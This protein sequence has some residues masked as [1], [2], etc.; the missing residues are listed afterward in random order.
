MLSARVRAGGL[1]RALIAGEDPATSRQLTARALQLTKPSSRAAIARALD[2]LL[3]NAQSP[4]GRWRVR[5][6]REAVCAN[7]S[8]LGALAAL[9][10]GPAPLYARGVAALDELL[11]DGTGPVYHGDAQALAHALGESRAAMTGVA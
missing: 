1:N 9:L 10:D 4:R 8:A 6:H 3:W 11:S 7:A 5:P 2:G